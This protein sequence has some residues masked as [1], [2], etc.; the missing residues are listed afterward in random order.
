E[1]AFSLDPD[2]IL[3]R[4]TTLT[5]QALN[6]LLGE[7]FLYE[8][9]A[10]NQL[11]LRAISG[12]G[13]EE[14]WKLEHKLKFKL[15]TGLVG[16][17]GLHRQ[18]I[19]VS[20]IKQDHRWKHVPGTDEG[21][22]SALVAPI[23]Q[24]ES[25]LGVLSLLHNRPNAFTDDHLELLQAICHQVGLALS[26]AN[27]YQQVQ[28]LVDL[29][30]AEQ[31]RLE[32]LMEHLPA[33]VLL[34]D[35]D[36]H[37]V[38][39]N[40]TGRKILALFGSGGEQQAI[41][42]LGPC[43]IE[44]LT[45]F[46]GSPLPVEIT[47]EGPPQKV[48]EVEARPLGDERPQWVITVREVTQE[49]ANQARIQMQER[50]ATVGQ[51]AAGIAHDFNNI[52]AAIMVY[53]DLLRR[54]MDLLP[55]GSERVVI[56]QK[57]VQR[58]SSLIRQILDFSRRS[59]MEQST[60]DMLPFIKEM[61]KLL[62]RLLPETIQFELNFQPG[63]YLVK[64]DPTRLQQVFMNL[65]LNARDAMPQG[66]TLSFEIS[67]L[68]ITPGE[69]PPLPDLEAGE[70]IRLGVSDTGIGIPSEALPH[71][72]EPFF[73]TKAYGEGTGLGLAQAYGIIKQ[74]GGHI[75][76]RSR[77]GEGSS[78]SIYLPALPLPESESE[79]AEAYSATPGDGETI[80]L[81]EDDRVTREALLA[82][83]EAHDYRVLV[84]S[85]GRDALQIYEQMRESI[86][87]VVSDVVMPEMGGV[88]LYRALRQRWPQVKMLLITGHPLRKEDQ[89]VLEGGSVQWLQKPFSI[90]DFSLLIKE[91]LS[92]EQP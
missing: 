24:G 57:Q 66:G 61:D 6:G 12:R 3:D 55:G 35:T 67:R 50:L 51:L 33:G 83:L 28:S 45:G 8:P 86:D 72:F 19:K 52:M 31:N 53:T 82:M 18:A 37:L 90:P 59:V 34:L 29:L 75:D 4:A 78:F 44:D 80:L 68:N 71:I 65:A 60:L 40:S 79:S 64:G 2:E 81:V 21:V 88:E 9:D 49:R 47:F 63:T 10:G 30:A 11:S 23:L 62:E 42:K 16:W 5:C 15:G 26:N 70:W 87:L 91:L 74:H 54:D 56:I 41:S 17:V 13:R 25:L 77:L 48:F 73:S 27:R 20:D 92:E 43:S 69:S 76:V 1:L 22:H 38:V 36:Y 39:A 7:A 84:S 58:A 46:S 89:A 85:N 32:S 14:V